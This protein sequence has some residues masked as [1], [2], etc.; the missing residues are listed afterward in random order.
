MDRGEGVG[1]T[2]TTSLVNNSSLV[3]LDLNNIKIDE[4]GG[5]ALARVVRENATLQVLDLSYRELN[6]PDGIGRSSWPQVLAALKYNVGL[7]TLRLYQC[8]LT[9]DD[10][11]LLAESLAQR[12]SGLMRYLDVSV[13][14]F[15]D[16][17]CSASAVIMACLKPDTGLRRLDICHVGDGRATVHTCTGRRSCSKQ[18]AASTQ[19]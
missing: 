19:R 17:P 11:Q 14:R 10:G 7:H 12:P 5:V 13:N 3:E 2:I 4:V 6:Y 15:G 8:N 1:L 9:S 16:S 18:H